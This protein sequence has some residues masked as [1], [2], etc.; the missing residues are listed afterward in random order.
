APEPG[1]PSRHVVL[2]AT[3]PKKAPDL[4]LLTISTAG[5]PVEVEESL[6][7]DPEREWGVPQADELLPRHLATTWEWGV[8][9]PAGRP[10]V[11]FRLADLR[12]SLTQLPVLPVHNI[13]S[14]RRFQ[15]GKSRLT[16]AASHLA[17]PVHSR[18]NHHETA[19][20]TFSPGSAEWLLLGT[21]LGSQGDE[22]ALGEVDLFHVSADG[23]RHLH[24]DRLP[25]GPAPHTL[26][27]SPWQ[28]AE[29]VVWLAEDRADPRRSHVLQVALAQAGGLGRPAGSRAFDLARD[30][31]P[32][33]FS[34]AFGEEETDIV[35]AGRD[36]AS[37]PAVVNE[38]SL[39][40]YSLLL[41]LGTDRFLTTGF[42]YRP[43]V[44][45]LKERREEA[46][47]DYKPG[48]TTVGAASETGDLFALPGDTAVTATVHRRD[49]QG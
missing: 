47:L 8:L 38:G 39:P 25:A 37:P 46:R 15:P 27:R 44:W 14:S 18:T 11:A 21:R 2:V 4:R 24:S 28:P 19:G 13:V 12:Q 5:G 33:L 1:N 3:R 29:G 7:P 26:F 22:L 35:V 48:F 32:Q 17:Q 23:F 20:I 34:Y 6:V 31:D 45:N 40:P 16:V 10:P 43:R 42:D 30:D 9:A 36:P 41:P 49:A